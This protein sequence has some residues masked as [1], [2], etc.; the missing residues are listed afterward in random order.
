M[1]LGVGASGP[2][3]NKKKVP[4]YEFPLVPYLLCKR[5][6]SVAENP[7]LK[8]RVRTD[9]HDNDIAKPAQQA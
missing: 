3:K 2:S 4:R 8:G 1:T 9:V 7:L 5:N 6:R